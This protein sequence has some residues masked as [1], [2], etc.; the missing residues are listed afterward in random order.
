MNWA[1]QLREAAKKTMVSPKPSPLFWFTTSELFLKPD[2]EAN[3]PRPLPAYLRQPEIVFKR[4][5]A[6]PAEDKFL[7]LAD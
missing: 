2:P 5:W 4:I 7:N 6:L 1:H 3:E